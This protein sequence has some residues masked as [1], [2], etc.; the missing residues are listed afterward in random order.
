M[1]DDA[2]L[3]SLIELFLTIRVTYSLCSLSLRSDVND[4]D[5]LCVLAPRLPC[6]RRGIINTPVV[7]SAERTSVCRERRKE[8][9]PRAMYQPNKK[10]Q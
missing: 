10:P 1:Y 8:P 4:V 9:L 2:D 7:L 6:S 3:C 5:V